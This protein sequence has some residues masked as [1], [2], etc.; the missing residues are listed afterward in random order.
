[1][2]VAKNYEILP[3]LGRKSQTINNPAWFRSEIETRGILRKRLLFLEIK[4]HKIC[5]GVSYSLSFIPC[6][7]HG[8]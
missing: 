1:M 4:V 6:V 3:G 2:Q 5:Q 8:Y 7:I